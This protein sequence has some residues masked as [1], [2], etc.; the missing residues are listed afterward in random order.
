MALAMTENQI[1]RIAEQRMDRLDREYLNTVM[2]SNTYDEEV[3]KIKDWADAEYRKISL[4]PF[5][6]EA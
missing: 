1:E 3:R 5:R 2:D 6:M 4:A